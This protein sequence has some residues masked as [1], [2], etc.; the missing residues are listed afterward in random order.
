M[1]LTD[2]LKDSNYKLSQF[3]PEQVETLEQRI[4]I[5]PV[6]GKEQAFVEC[7]VR[8]KDIQLKPEEAIEQNEAEAMEYIR[9]ETREDL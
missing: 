1:K 6:R 4:F 8:K 7:L 5:K 2:I 9:A 3:S